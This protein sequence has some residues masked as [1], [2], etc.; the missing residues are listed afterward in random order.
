MNAISWL[1]ILPINEDLSKG[2]ALTFCITDS[3]LLLF[4]FLAA[5]TEPGYIKRDQNIDF[6]KLLD[7]TDPYNLCPDCKVLRTP[8]SRHCNI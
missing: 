5:I 3:L 2:F 6:Q 1:F 7:S 4:F 8:R